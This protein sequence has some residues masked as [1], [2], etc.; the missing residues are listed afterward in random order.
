MG[1]KDNLTL[2]TRLAELREMAGAAAALAADEA[3]FNRAVEAFRARDAETFQAVLSAVGLLNKCKLICQFFCAK[4]AIRICVVFCKYPRL[5]ADELDVAEIRAFAAVIGR[6]AADEALLESFV[7]AM[8]QEDTEAFDQ[9][10]TSQKL[11]PYCPQLCQ[12]LSSVRCRRVCKDMCPQPPLITEVSYIPV[13]Q[14]TSSGPGIGLGAGASVPPGSTG[15]D[16]KSPGGSGDH[17]F[18]G[19]ANIQGVFSIAAP[20][21]YKVEYSASTAGPWTP[22]VQP[23]TDEHWVG[24]TLVNFTRV[25]DASGW[26]NVSDMG[27]LGL[28]YLTDWPT[29]PADRNTTYYLKL[30][31]RN[32]ALVQFESPLVPARVDNG[33]P[34]KPTITLQLQAPDGTLTTLGC[35]QTVTQGQVNDKGQGNQVLI[36][37]TGTD[38]NFSGIGASLL[39]G[40]GSSPAFTDSSGN[41]ITIGKTY[42]GDITD[43]GYPA[44]TPGTFLWDPWATGGAGPVS[45]CCY[46]IYVT[47]TDRAIVNNYW[48]GA[49]TSV[50]WQSIT[51]A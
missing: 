17:P 19:T 47:I 24:L 32:A 42:N 20:T 35:C 5:T 50:N 26:Y 51:I 21:Q 15:P 2:D 13:S 23:I 29:P 36:T 1:Q 10:I 9:L 22:I 49:H 39:G 28:N 45:P 7:K 40:C 48:S 31:V 41:P 16:S 14:I 12:W 27:L 8:D 34:T 11:E 33:L 4:Y 3:S 43:T 37:L 25:P 46:V 6:I 18:G 38:E 30:T 44:A